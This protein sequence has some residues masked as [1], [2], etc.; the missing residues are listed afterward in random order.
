MDVH[1][2]LLS[3]LAA[4][5]LLASMAGCTGS[6]EVTDA[7]D[8]AGVIKDGNDGAADP[9][10]RADGMADGADYGSDQGGDPGFDAGPDE[11]DEYIPDGGGSCETISCADLEWCLD[12]ICHCQSGWERQGPD[13]LP[14]IPTDFGS[15]TAAGVCAKWKADYSTKAAWVWQAGADD[16]DDGTLNP[17]SIDDGIRRI[18]LFRWLVGLYPVFNKR[19]LNV[20]AQPCAVMIKENGSL[21]HQPPTDWNC[22]TAEGASGAS[23]SNECMGRSDPAGAIDAYIG[24][25]NVSS[26][27]HRRWLLDPPYKP[28]GIGQATSWNCTYVMTGGNEFRPDWLAYPP[29][30]PCPQAAILG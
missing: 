15:R 2:R 12:G 25:N 8:D 17:E 27:G 9:G 6:I 13:C 18:N 4:A 7:G 24:D 3:V 21:N 1:R 22:Y 11:G 28:A 23:N 29:P 26:L 10:D 14:V 20:Y 5:F 19:T 16:C 30:G